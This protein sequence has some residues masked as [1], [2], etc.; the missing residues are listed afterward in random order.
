VLLT[1]DPWTVENTLM[2]PTLKLKRLNLMAHFEVA[3]NAMYAPR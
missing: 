2:T 1:L 3:L